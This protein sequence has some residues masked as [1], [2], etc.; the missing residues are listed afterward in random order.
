MATRFLHKGLNAENELGD[1]VPFSFDR[2]KNLAAKLYNGAGTVEERF[3][4]LGGIEKVT[5]SKT[6]T[7]SDHGKTFLADSTTSVVLTL[8]STVAGIEFTLIVEQLT[9]GTG[10]AFSPAAADQ[11]IGNGFTPADDKDAICSGAT[12]RLGD[13]L[14]IVGDGEL[15]WYIKSVTGTWAR[16]V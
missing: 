6:I 10:H 4:P 11:I 5:A 12:D 3:A 15:G 16:E 7:L 8:P 9:A 13:A 14:T 1:K 2:N